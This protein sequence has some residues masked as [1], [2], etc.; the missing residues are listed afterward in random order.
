MRSRYLLIFFNTIIYY[1]LS[2][3]D[4]KGDTKGAASDKLLIL[5]GPNEFGKYAGKLTV[6]FLD[7]LAIESSPPIPLS[8]IGLYYN[9]GKETHGYM[10]LQ[11]HSLR[12]A[13]YL[14]QVRRTYKPKSVLKNR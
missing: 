13:D 5:L 7:A 14:R 4:G 9:H 1:F 6:P 10:S 12:Y 11:L 8:G 2:T 3:S